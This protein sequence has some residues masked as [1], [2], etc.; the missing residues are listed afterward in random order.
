MNTEHEKLDRIME[1]MDASNLGS[2]TPED[3]T[4]THNFLEAEMKRI[5][6]EDPEELI[7]C[8]CHGEYWPSKCVDVWGNC[9]PE[10]LE[11]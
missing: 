3:R 5:A 1:N 7:I 2:F 11:Q 9:H 6:E 10:L 4:L 8:N